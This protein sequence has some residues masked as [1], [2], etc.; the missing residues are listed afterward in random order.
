MNILGVGL[1]RTGTK[2]LTRALQILG[3]TTIHNDRERLNPII[4]GVDNAPDFRVY[5]DVDA[6]TDLPSAYFFREILLAYPAAKAILTVRETNSWLCSYRKHTS[7]RRLRRF[8][9]V[10]V[11]IGNALGLKKQVN[12]WK[13]Y[14]YKVA[15]RNLVYGSVHFREYLQRQ[16]YETHNASVEKEIPKDRLLIMNIIGGDGWEKLCP[17]LG[18]DLPSADFPQ[19]K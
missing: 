14:K 12:D 10:H 18:V 15:M 8:S 17:F 3:F 13:I 2:S 6:V 9:G 11:R 4:L 1:S 7:D 19:V 5:D 16:K